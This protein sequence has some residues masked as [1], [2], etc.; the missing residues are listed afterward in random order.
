MI[1]LMNIFL[2][3]NLTKAIQPTAA[4]HLAINPYFS[5]LKSLFLK[6]IKQD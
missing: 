2:L 3:P 6:Y 1:P 4:P 5:S